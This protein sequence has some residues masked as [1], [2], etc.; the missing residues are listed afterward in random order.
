MAKK[1]KQKYYDLIVDKENKT[2]EIL[3]YGVIGDSWFEESTTA[4]QF[5]ADFRNA[6]KD[7]D[8]INI[9]LNS[10]GGSVF[11]G[12][13]I[14][15]AISASTKEI[16]TYND[17]VCASMAA[18]LLL[19]VAGKNVHPAFN[20]LIMLH[21]PSTCAC[22]N[23]S[24]LQAAIDILDKCQSALVSS[25]CKNTGLDAKD[26]EKKYFD[27]KDH[28]FT[29]D[30]AL[31]EGFYSQIEDDVAEN[32]PEN[33]STMKFSDLIKYFDPKNSIMWPKDE[34]SSEEDEEET[35]EEILDQ[36][37]MDIKKLTAAYKLPEDSTEDAIVAH[38][39]KREQEIADLTTAKTK[40]ETDL[41][42]ANQTIVD[43]D[44]VIA[45]LK[46]EPGEKTATVTTDTDTSKGTSKDE[47]N[48]F[49]TALHA[50]LEIVNSK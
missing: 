21:S 31:Q 36:I 39:A 27:N 2:T 10:P 23:K 38:V 45:T 30:E 8:R 16:H 32:V 1:S 46:K 24:Q 15:N 22:G 29:A 19:S 17:G 9:R 35:T 4:K 42:T 6:E 43:K 7:S 20:S 49:W 40:A 44:A 13:A 18:V 50:N 5:V 34:E 33:A 11:D 25:I 48:D 26:V 37:D 41:A 12:L 3:I 47:P 14:F 28:W